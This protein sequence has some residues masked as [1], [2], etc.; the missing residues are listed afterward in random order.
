MKASAKAYGVIRELIVSG[1]LAPGERL[2]EDALT[3]V[4]GVSRTPVRE[5]LR[6]LA[7]EGFVTMDGAARTRVMDID[8]DGLREVYTLRAMIES[9]AAGRAAQHIDD[10]QIERLKI[11]AQTMEDAVEEGGEAIEKRY[12]PSNAEF[13]RIILQAARSPRLEVL[14]QIVMAVPLTMRTLTRYTEVDRRRSLMHHRD[15]IT[16]LAAHSPDWASSV[17]RSHIDAALHT[18]LANYTAEGADADAD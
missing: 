15:L 5:A 2:K 9:H 1:E 17:M 13:H 8:E 11:L 3:V 10:A 14:A 16:A 7:N 4:C 6:R 12:L 18:L